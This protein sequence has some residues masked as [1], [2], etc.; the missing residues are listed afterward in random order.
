MSRSTTLIK[1]LVSTHETVDTDTGEVL[2]TR[3]TYRTL[4]AKTSFITLYLDD[5]RI[6][7]MLS[8]LG[9]YGKVLGYILKTYNSQTATFH[10]SKT[11]K[12]LMVKEL[13]LNI[14]TVRAA[15]RAFD[16]RGMLCRVAGSEYM[17]NPRVFYKGRTEARVGLV[18]QFEELEKSKY[19]Q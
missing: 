2:Q 17:V 10:F 14:G 8:G 13:K 18:E 7:D 5:L 3:K 1:S 9:T 4:I 16:E 19:Q 6:F 12:D 15:V 11:A